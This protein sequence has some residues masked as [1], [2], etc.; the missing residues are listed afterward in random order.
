MP[1]VPEINV[2]AKIFNKL[3][4]NLLPITGYTNSMSLVIDRNEIIACIHLKTK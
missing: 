1:D 4:E 2:G 3:D